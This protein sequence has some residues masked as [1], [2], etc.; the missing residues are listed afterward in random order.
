MLSLSRRYRG[1]HCPGRPADRLGTAEQVEAERILAGLDE[2][3]TVLPV[4][5]GPADGPWV[6]R[7][8]EHLADV[9]REMAPRPDGRHGWELL[10][11]PTE[12]IARA[13]VDLGRAGVVELTVWAEGPEATR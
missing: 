4:Y 9:L 11:A 13:G 8:G 10:E 5:G 2:Q 3:T 6:L 7:V 12:P 1:K